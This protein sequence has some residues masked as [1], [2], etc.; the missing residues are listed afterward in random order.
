MPSRNRTLQWTVEW[1]H[2][3]GN[4]TTDKL[5][6]IQGISTAYDDHLRH[7]DTSR[8]RKR[9]KPDHKHTDIPLS[10]NLVSSSVPAHGTT[11]RE[12]TNGSTTIASVG[13]RK[14]EEDEA[15]MNR[16]AEGE[17]QNM[18]IAAVPG[19]SEAVKQSASL[20]ASSETWPVTDSAPRVDFNFYLHHPSLP[21]QHPVLIPLSPD[22]KLATALFNR[23]VLEF[24]TIYVLHNQPD[25][26]LPEGFVSEED[27]FASA[28]KE[29]VEEIADE[30]TCVGGFARNFEEKK[31][32]DLKNGEVD[33]GRLLE[34]VGKDLKGFAGS[35]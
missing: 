21:S 17:D 19:D 8:P 1:V 16:S 24:P 32:H 18:A 15:N 23:L 33:E 5:W 7:L 20:P 6:E 2:P 13:K 26:K 25:A 27:F 11:A 31:T 35:L 29:L 14:R 10:A 22:A 28:K 34:V 12:Q 3:D 30:K 4:K 9:R